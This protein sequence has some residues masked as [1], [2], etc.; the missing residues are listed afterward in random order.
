MPFFKA[1]ANVLSTP[2]NDNKDFVRPSRI[3]WLR[4]GQDSLQIV[5]DPAL[6][7]RP[8]LVTRHERRRVGDDQSLSFAIIIFTASLFQQSM[9]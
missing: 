7:T 5:C 9:P 4:C 3:L 8:L 2:S 6:R 1:A